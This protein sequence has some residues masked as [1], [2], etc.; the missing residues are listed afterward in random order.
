VSTWSYPFS[1][2]DANEDWT[3][4]GSWDLW[5][6]DGTP[7][8][9]FAQMWPEVTQPPSS[10]D[11]NRVRDFTQLAC[12]QAAPR[13]LKVEAGQFLAAYNHLSGPVT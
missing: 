12:W 5:N 3:K 2:A 10:A 13:Q 11:V 7:V 9:T 8:T 1:R 4:L 6:H